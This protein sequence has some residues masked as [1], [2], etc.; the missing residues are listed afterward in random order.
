MTSLLARTAALP[1]LLGLLAH[2]L[3]RA[4]GGLVPAMD[5]QVRDQLALDLTHECRSRVG[6]HRL[7]SAPHFTAEEL[8]GDPAYGLLYDAWL[9]MLIGKTG[10][11]EGWATVATL[12]L[13]DTL[14][15]VAGGH[16]LPKGRQDRDMEK[17]YREF[18]GSFRETGLRYRLSAE[19]VRQLLVPYIEAERAARQRDLFSGN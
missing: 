3:A 4:L 13:L 10:L 11:P 6:G 5:A 1:D 15:Q 16:Y 12:R 8:R 7:V 18:R 9:A 19:R 2:D 17:M 14:R